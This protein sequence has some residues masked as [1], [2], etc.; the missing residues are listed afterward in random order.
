MKK[1]KDVK[2]RIPGQRNR[3][4]SVWKGIHRRVYK[5][6]KNEIGI[7][8]GCSVCD[9]WF[10]YSN[11][12]KWYD[13]HYI[14][15]YNIDKDILVQGNKIYCPEYCCFVPSVINSIFTRKKP[16]ESA[17]VGVK[18]T[19][20]F[21]KEIYTS[22]NNDWLEKKIVCKRGKT[23]EDAYGYYVDT[24][25]DYIKR[26]ADYFK[27]TLEERVY[28]RLYNYQMN[29]YEEEKEIQRKYFP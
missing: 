16:K 25:L 5:P 7:Y 18:K 8:D 27:D 22:V 23:E 26:I 21:R 1:I 13:E 2:D 11:F 6:N 19:I 28:E 15:G 20:E 10:L 12:K 9:E 3:C 24:R 4:Y 29:T 14:E 17:V